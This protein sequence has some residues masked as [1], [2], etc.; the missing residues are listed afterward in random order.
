ML[1]DQDTNKLE[2]TVTCFHLYEG[3]RCWLGSGQIPVWL[4]WSSWV[5]LSFW[6]A[7]LSSSPGR[8]S[9][10]TAAGSVLL[11]CCFL[12]AALKRPCWLQS[13]EKPL[14]SCSLFSPSLGLEC[15]WKTGGLTVIHEGDDEWE[16]DDTEDPQTCCH[17]VEDRTQWSFTFIFWKKHICFSNFMQNNNNFS[18]MSLM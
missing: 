6:S 7:P 1:E 11:S 15:P 3:S 13:G 18:H 8:S 10:S 5:G 4:P 14:M 9:E 12:C 16:Q 17:Q 2:D